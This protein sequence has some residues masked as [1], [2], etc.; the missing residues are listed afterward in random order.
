MEFDD[1]PLIPE[2]ENDRMNTLEA[3]ERIAYEKEKIKLQL[4]KEFTPPSLKA[5]S[6]VT[7]YER[8]RLAQL[9]LLASPF[10]SVEFRSRTIDLFISNY[11]EYGISLYRKGRLETKDVIKSFYESSALEQQSTQELNQE[12]EDRSMRERLRRYLL[13]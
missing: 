3:L 7:T 8:Y 5:K 2:D 11:L 4:I 12:E 6:E 9:E 10:K 13:E 1:I